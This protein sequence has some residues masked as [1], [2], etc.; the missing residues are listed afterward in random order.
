MQLS[1]LLPPPDFLGLFIFLC[2]TWKH[3][4]QIQHAQYLPQIAHR[5][6]VGQ[7]IRRRFE[8]LPQTVRRL[9]PER[10]QDLLQEAQVGFGMSGFPV[11]REENGRVAS[12][13]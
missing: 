3:V 4:T 6:L 5:R 10:L 9:S 12:R 13:N 8:A 11:V 7:G 2:P 1:L